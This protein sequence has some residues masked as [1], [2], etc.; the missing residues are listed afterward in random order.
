MSS[1]ALHIRDIEMDAGKNN[2]CIE[3]GSSRGQSTRAGLLMMAIAQIQTQ[4]RC[5]YS[6]HYSFLL[7][8]PPMAREEEIH[9]LRSRNFRTHPGLPFPSLCKTIK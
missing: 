6:A 1:E 7:L 3:R 8:L 4:I 9:L 2:I 5:L